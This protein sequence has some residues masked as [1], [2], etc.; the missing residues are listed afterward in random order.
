MRQRVRAYGP[1]PCR[2]QNV[3]RIAYKS[4]SIQYANCHSTGHDFLP[5][6]ACPRSL[7]G[8]L[9]AGALEPER[10]RDSGGLLDTPTYI[11]ETGLRLALQK[12]Q[13]RQKQLREQHLQQGQVQRGQVKRGRSPERETQSLSQRR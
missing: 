5:S 4:G 10:G 11:A 7:L 6:R 9:L 12:E 1:L 3:L 2:C 13:L 8:H